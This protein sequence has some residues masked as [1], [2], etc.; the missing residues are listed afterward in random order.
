[1]ER[2]RGLLSNTVGAVSS[3]ICH[4]GPGSVSPGAIA[5]EPLL[6]CAR[7]AAKSQIRRSAAL[8]EIDTPLRQV[9]FVRP[10]TSSLRVPAVVVHLPTV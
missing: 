5:W 4:F 1:V 10:A 9:S 6:D 7:D 8:L 2:E 3:S